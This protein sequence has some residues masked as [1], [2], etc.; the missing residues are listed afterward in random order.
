MEQK[1]YTISETSKALRVQE[2]T[3]RAWV[4][5]GRLPVVRL[6]SRVFV[7]HETVGAIL[8]EGLQSVSSE[9]H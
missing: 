1:I 3:I 4:H 6:G 9:T 2:S 5:Q 7:K 8:K